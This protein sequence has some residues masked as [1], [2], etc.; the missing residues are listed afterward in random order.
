[1]TH[2]GRF[3]AALVV[4]FALTSAVRAADVAPVTLVTHEPSGETQTLT[5]LG[6]GA[7]TVRKVR[8][9]GDLDQLLQGTATPAELSAI[10]DSLAKARL[11]RTSPLPATGPVRLDLAATVD[12]KPVNVSG[13]LGFFS[14]GDL[15]PLT[16]ALADVENRVGATGAPIGGSD[17]SA[18]GPNLSLSLSVRPATTGLA[19]DIQVSQ[20]FA[21]NPEVT[22]TRRSPDQGN[23]ERTFHGTLTSDELVAVKAGMGRAWLGAGTLPAAPAA[24]ATEARETL[25]VSASPDAGGKGE[26]GTIAGGASY[27]AAHAHRLQPLT[28]ALRAIAARLTASEAPVDSDLPLPAMP[29]SA[30]SRTA[31][32]LNPATGL[33]FAAPT[34]SADPINPVTGLPDHEKVTAIPAPAVPAPA[35]L[36]EGILNA[37]DRS[38]EGR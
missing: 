18:P 17:A 3:V 14:T 12:G 24:N 9:D 31:Q 4:M 26:I 35:P 28:D 27:F 6:D 8:P 23:I 29:R 38:A 10:Q 33:P 25:V 37:I 32:P 16:R 13:D 22:V 15:L 19:E 36:S 34:K 21:G 7:V 30:T 2:P 1:M 5:V 20:S 11:A